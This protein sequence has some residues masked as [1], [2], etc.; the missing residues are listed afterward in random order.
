[1]TKYDWSNVPKDVKWIATDEDRNSWEF[2]ADTKEPFIGGEDEDQWVCES[3]FTLEH[4][5]F[6]VYRGNWQDSLEE[7]PAETDLPETVVKSLGEVE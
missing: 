3:E 1:M 6:R 4:H 2:P 7:R 5:G